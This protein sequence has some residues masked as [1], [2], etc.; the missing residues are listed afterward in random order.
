MAKRKQPKELK[1]EVIFLPVAD[2]DAR[3]K[4]IIKLLLRLSQDQ[5][6][7]LKGGRNAETEDD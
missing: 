6:E 5:Y 3:L 2:W 1:V 7:N 4:K